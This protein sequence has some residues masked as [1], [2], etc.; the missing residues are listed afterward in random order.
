M[1]EEESYVVVYSRKGSFRVLG[2]YE[3]YD[4]AKDR[5]RNEVENIYDEPEELKQ[6]EDYYETDRMKDRWW[7]SS[8]EYH[9]SE[10]DPRQEMR[11]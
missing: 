7:I 9:P 2:I 11:Y 1:T 3:L 8:G 10:N 5:L 4:D 6:G